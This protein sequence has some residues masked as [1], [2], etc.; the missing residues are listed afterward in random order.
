MAKITGPLHSDEGTGRLGG[1][2]IFRNRKGVKYSSAFYF[3][4]SKKK[5]KVSTKQIETRELYQKGATAWSALSENQKAQYIN[6]AKGRRYSGYNLFMQEYL[7][8]IIMAELRF[9]AYDALQE[10]LTTALNALANNGNKLGAAI[11]FAAAGV[12]RKIYMDVEIYLASVNLSAQ[13]NPAVNLWLLPRIDGVNFEDG[14]DAVDPARAPDK[15]V[16]L[17]EVNG[18]QRVAARFLLTNPDQ[19]KILIENKTGATLAGSGNT[20]KYR[21]YS[22]ETA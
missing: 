21:I 22:E 10:Y 9:T 20:I 4:G 15:V 17:R 18:A 19:A 12:D 5:Y 7:I 2:Q 6:H 16:A 1:A 13:D 11:D 3:P 8:L 14:A